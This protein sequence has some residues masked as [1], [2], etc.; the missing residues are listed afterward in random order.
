MRRRYDSGPSMDRNTS[1]TPAVS[2]AAASGQE[3][4]QAEAG[5]HQGIG[6]G[7]RHR[8]EVIEVVVPEVSL[9]MAR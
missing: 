8:G 1:A 5:Q 7:F 3:S 6:L 4:D 9:A 2:G